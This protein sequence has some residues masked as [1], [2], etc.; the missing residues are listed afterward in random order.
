M[1]PGLHSASD[2]RNA[3]TQQSAFRLRLVAMG[4][5]VLVCFSLLVWRWSVL[6]IARH[7]TYLE[8]AERNRTALLAVDLIESLFGK[9]TL[10]R[11]HQVRKSTF[12]T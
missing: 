11:E 3:E 6:Q 4:A 1:I 9:S 5:L 7:D 12:Q 2:I 10:M 8:Q